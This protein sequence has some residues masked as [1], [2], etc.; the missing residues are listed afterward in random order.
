MKVTRLLSEINL[1]ANT[2]CLMRTVTCLLVLHVQKS[3]LIKKAEPVKTG[4]FP[5]KSRP[6]LVKTVT[7]AEITHA[8]KS[9]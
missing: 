9:Q 4:H 2:D 5:K 7:F 1:D 8:A 6:Y 3:N